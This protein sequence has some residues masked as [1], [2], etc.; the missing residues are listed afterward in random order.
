MEILALLPGLA[1]AFVSLRRSPAVAFLNIYLPVLLLCPDYYHCKIVQGLPELSFTHAAILPIAAVMLIR[2]FQWRWS[3]ADFLVFGFAFWLGFSEYL[4]AGYKEAQNLMFDMAT[5]VILPYVCT[6]AIVEPLG[7]RVAFARRLAWLA[8]LVSVIS[9]YEFRMGA[10]LFRRPF[11][12]FFPGQGFGWV[13]TFRWGYARIAGPYSHAILAGIVMLSAWRISRWLEW[14]G[15]WESRLA[16]WQRLPVTK[17]RVISLGLL[18]G[19]LMTMTRGPWLGAILAAAIATVGRSTKRKKAFRVLGAGILLIGIPAGIALYRYSAVGRAAAK[20]PA[21]ETAAYRKELIDKYVAIVLDHSVWGWGR[22]TWP[23]VPGMPSI[24]NYYLLLALMHGLPAMVFFTSI[25][26]AMTIRLMLAGM[27]QLPP[28]RPGSSLAFTLAG[29]YLGI[30][31]AVAT[32]YMGKQVIPLFAMLTGWS[33]GYLLS[34]KKDLQVVSER[35]TRLPQVPVF[36][37]VLA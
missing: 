4:N 33:E 13:T 17:G 16:I 2:R 31:F 8:F 11:D 25:V 10:T 30:A 27:R 14:S 32:V 12:P 26:A 5:S 34:Q 29:I 19:L 20:S 36:R 37:R 22:N 15:R 21:Q 3:P 23:K 7:L 6:K 9:V 35:R 28:I 18:G 1:A 24:D